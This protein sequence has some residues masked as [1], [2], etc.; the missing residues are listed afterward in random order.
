MPSHRDIKRPLSNNHLSWRLKDQNIKDYTT[1]VMQIK[2]GVSTYKILNNLAIN[3]CVLVS[4]EK[5]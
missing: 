1:N 2:T 3:V 4:G 5:Q